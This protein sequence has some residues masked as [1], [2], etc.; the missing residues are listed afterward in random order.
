MFLHLTCISWGHFLS[1][2]AVEFKQSTRIS[3]SWRQL[4]HDEVLILIGGDEKYATSEFDWHPNV[5]YTQGAIVRMNY[6]V[7]EERE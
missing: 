2:R 3:G 7:L 5:A 4:S 6:E 1:K